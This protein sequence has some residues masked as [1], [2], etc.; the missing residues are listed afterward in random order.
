MLGTSFPD[1]L[2]PAL[3]FT[4][5]GWEGMSGV[6]PGLLT[7][8]HVEGNA[9]AE[10]VPGLAKAMPTISNGNKT[11]K[12]T[13]RKNL[14]FSDGTPVKASDF[15]HSIERLLAQDSQGSSFFTSIAGSDEYVKTKKGGLSGI[16]ADDATGEI[17]INLSEPQSTF[18][19]VLATP[20]GGVVPGDTPAKNMTKDPPPSAGYYTIT[21][22]KPPN[23]Y[24]LVKNTKFSPGLKGTD[25]DQGNVDQIDVKIV[26]SASNQVTQVSNNRPTS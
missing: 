14:N 3:S 21:N 26:R 15:K 11:Y 5:D 12:F 9:G 13:L 2:D 18:L 4:V 8:P 25:V 19:F 16:K 1:Y 24:T 6:Y 17:T 22:S 20:F 10:P 23:S 7:Y